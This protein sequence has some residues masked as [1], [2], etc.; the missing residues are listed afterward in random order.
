[1]IGPAPANQPAF[2]LRHFVDAQAP[3]WDRVRAELEAGRKA[4]HWMWFVFPQ[5]AGLGSSPMARRFCHRPR[6]AKRVDYL[7]HPVLGAR[8][9][10]ATVLVNAVRRRSAHEIF[11]SPDD[12]KFRSSMTLFAEVAGGPSAFRDAL[13]KYYE[14]LGYPLTLQRLG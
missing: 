3:V 11:G 14:G 8:L 10:D 13:D 5:I 4:G 2:D 12:L 9:R 7:A 6:A 1:M